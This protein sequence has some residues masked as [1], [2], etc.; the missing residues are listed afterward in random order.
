MQRLSRSLSCR[1]DE[2]SSDSCFDTI[3]TRSTAPTEL[4]PPVLPIDVLLDIFS[5]AVEATP[6]AKDR[7]ALC[8]SIATLS[9][10]WTDIGL[11]LLYSS[12]LS[13]RAKLF[14]SRKKRFSRFYR[15]VLSDD[16]LASA[17]QSLTIDTTLVGDKLTALLGC[18]TGLKKLGL[19][20][21]EVPICHLHS[22][23]R[24]TSL[25]LSGLSLTADSPRFFKSSLPY[26]FTLADLPLVFPHLTHLTLSLVWL[27]APVVPKVLDATVFPALTHLTT[28]SILSWTTHGVR[29]GLFA[30][31]PPLTHL[32]ILDPLRWTR[33]ALLRCTI[34]SPLLHL[35][36]AE[37]ARQPASL[38]HVLPFLVAAPHSL[39]TLHLHA[40][41]I[42]KRAT[43]TGP[44][45]GNAL[46][47]LTRGLILA[48]CER[49]ESVVELKKLTLGGPGWKDV[50]ALR[51]SIEL[52]VGVAG[53]RGVEVCCCFDEDTSG[54]VD[55]EQ[56]WEP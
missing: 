3:E 31:S 24:V 41:A 48:L 33:H 47:V 35:R 39:Q 5:L 49:R 30:L 37:A 21:G 44:G 18:C 26:P 1:S 6:S 54:W 11:R 23:S 15:T 7:Q 36:V 42:P 10:D 25:S 29:D 32:T 16:Y 45:G 14:S 19:Q 52:L 28:A 2:S 34:T 27:T 22:A 4:H 38:R 56:E 17:V 20:K 46:P 40:R 55:G 12:H 51:E 8:L 13:F 50:P 43:H 53:T 9:S